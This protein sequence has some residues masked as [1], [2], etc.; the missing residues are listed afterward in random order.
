MNSPSRH[1]RRREVLGTVPGVCRLEAGDFGLHLTKAAVTD[2]GLRLVEVI[3]LASRAH[4]TEPKTT[5]AP[6]LRR[7]P[8]TRLRDCVND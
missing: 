1:D 6:V 2:H 5:E 3:R 4:T 8:R 7:E